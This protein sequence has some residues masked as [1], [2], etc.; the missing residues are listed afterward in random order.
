MS[1]TIFSLDIGTRSVVG[2]ILEEINGNYEVLDLITMEHKERSMIDG[3]IHN[4]LTVAEV[5]KNI[6]EQLEQKH[7][8]LK[9]S[10]SLRQDGHF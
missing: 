7:G 2:T 3:Q 8:P 5:I 4:I 1:S 6:K 9:K 10:V